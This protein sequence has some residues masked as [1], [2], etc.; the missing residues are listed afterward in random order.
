MGNQALTTRLGEYGITAFFFKKWYW[1]CPQQGQNSELG[2]TNLATKL[3]LFKPII[4]V[5][6]RLLTRNYKV[7]N[8]FSFIVLKNRHF[9]LS[10]STTNDEWIILFRVSIKLKCHFH[11]ALHSLTDASFST[12]KSQVLNTYITVSLTDPASLSRVKNSSVGRK[13]AYTDFQL[14]SLHFCNKH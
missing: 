7:K 14:R 6:K 11:T 3:C 2:A 4:H 8:K 10:L 5:K 9:L 1:E 13:I 12:T